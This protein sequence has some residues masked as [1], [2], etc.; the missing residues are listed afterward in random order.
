MMMRL[1]RCTISRRRLSPRRHRSMR[2]D[3]RNALPK[4]K[5]TRSCAPTAD[6]TPAPEKHLLPLPPL[7]SQPKRANL[8]HSVANS[9]AGKQPIDLMAPQGSFMAGLAL[10]AAFALAASVVWFLIAWTTGFTVGY[11][12]ILIGGAAGA[13]MK[14]GQKGFSST[15]GTAAAALTLAAIMC[16]KFAVIEVI[17]MRAG[18]HKSIF[19]LSGPALGYYFFSPIGLIIIVIGMGAAFRTANGSISD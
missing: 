8:Q 16:A 7:P 19:D 5:M 18:S 14:I 13:G 9:K 3:V 17:L 6:T 12:A 1:A 2:C 15:G 10:S 11:I 4:W